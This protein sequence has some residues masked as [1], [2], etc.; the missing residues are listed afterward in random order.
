M[1]ASIVSTSWS[2]LILHVLLLTANDL[3]GVHFQ[4]PQQQSAIASRRLDAC[5]IRNHARDSRMVTYHV[6]HWYSDM[7]LKDRVTL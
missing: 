1:F 4:K 2:I 5:I 7:G 3:L 6:H